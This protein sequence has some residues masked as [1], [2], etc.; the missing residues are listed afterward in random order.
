MSMDVLTAHTMMRYLDHSF[1][2]IRRYNE[3]EHFV[4]LQYDQR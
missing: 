2:N 1:D 3:Y 4:G